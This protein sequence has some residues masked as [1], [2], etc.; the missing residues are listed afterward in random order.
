M[1]PF[2]WCRICPSIRHINHLCTLANSGFGSSSTEVSEGLCL[3]GSVHLE[4]WE[5]AMLLSSSHKADPLHPGL[6]LFRSS[7]LLSFLFFLSHALSLADSGVLLGWSKS[8]S[9]HE[10]VFCRPPAKRND[11]QFSRKARHN[12]HQSMCLCMFICD[13]K[14]KGIVRPKFVIDSLIK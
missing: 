2:H 7:L 5:S 1:L 3:S 8:W 9:C 11:T 4:F 12:D 14:M 6:I 13:I 10:V